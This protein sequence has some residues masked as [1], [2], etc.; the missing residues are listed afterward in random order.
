M[1]IDYISDIHTDFW[2]SPTSQH[3]KL[4][5]QLE[6]FITNTLKPLDAD[7][8]AIAGDL[9]H[10]FNQD[11]E[12]LLALNKHYKDIIL[13]PGN[14]DMYLVG[15]NQERYKLN[16][17][18]RMQEMQAFCDGYEGIH[19][20]NGQVLE[21]NGKRIGG[22]SMW[23]DLPTESEIQLWTETMNDSRLIMEDT[24]PY[25]VPFGYGG[26]ML[27]PSFDTQK[28]YNEQIE[29]LSTMTDLDLLVTHVAPILIPEYERSRRFRGY[30]TNIFYESDNKH[31]VQATGT[32]KVI[33]G[34]THDRQEYNHSKINFYCNPLG[35][36]TEATLNSIQ[37]ITI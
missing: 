4:A 35:Y 32:K 24:K 22:L 2:V 37:Q 5:R 31:L 23:Y 27:V 6:H 21:L 13:I 36:K 20:L 1:K 19:Y 28:Y 29:A 26:S 34:H 10:Y 16:S 18:L 30:A 9:G 33:Y 7:V 11:S 3:D 12:L 17:H 14:H 8:L 25:T 15:N